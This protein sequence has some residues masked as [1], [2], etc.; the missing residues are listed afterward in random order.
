MAAPQKRRALRNVFI[1]YASSDR[2]FARRLARD[3]RAQGVTVWI[4]ETGIRRG[5]DW[6]K[7][8]EKAIKDCEHVLLVLSPA[9][10]R[11]KYVRA[12][13]SFADDL[14]KPFIPI[15]RK[16]C[17]PWF[18]VTEHH[19]DFTG[20]YDEGFAQ[21]LKKEVPRRTLS[22]KFLLLLIR[23]RVILPV[24]AAV[25]AI[26]AAA[27]FLWPSQ[28]SFSFVSSDASGIILVL[29]RNAGGRPATLLGNEFMLDFGTLPIEPRRLEL[30]E[31]RKVS[32]LPGHSKQL[33]EL[34]TSVPLTP[35]PREERSY[36]TL[37]Q[38]LPLLPEATVRLSTGVRESD[39]RSRHTPLVLPATDIQNFIARTYPL[40][41]RTTP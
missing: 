10:K 3:L 6:R 40:D 37:E 21:L 25:T 34:T 18:N 39:G 20:L 28:T 24:L 15:L 8:I 35:R 7:K 29:A 5:D 30:L 27:Y 2:R 13:Y 17:E 22:R 33:I 32:D 9:A 4:D 31:P 11:A 23:L 41:V 26:A 16:R 1:S 12:E 19:A 14:H 36:F 38:L